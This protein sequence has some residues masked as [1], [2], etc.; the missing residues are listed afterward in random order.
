[1]GDRDAVKMV[2]LNQLVESMPSLFCA[3]GDCAYTP[4]EH[5]VPIYR[6]ADA[7]RPKYDNFIF[8][9]SQLRIRIEMAFGLMVK[10][11]GLLSR[12]LS[13]KM[14]NVK[15][16]MVTIARLHNFCINERLRDA[17][18][19]TPTGSVSQ[20][21]PANVA[22]DQ[23]TASLRD[24]AANEEFRKKELAYENPWSNN[25]ERMMSI[26]ECLQLMRPLSVIT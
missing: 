10:K 9:A 14:S 5:L 21:A 2:A 20:F 6:G 26:I 8:F 1:M 18:Q 17:N 13:I 3:I 12:P 7:R 23:Y 11:W 24:T 4:T 19:S 22:F 25:R 16:L 15:H